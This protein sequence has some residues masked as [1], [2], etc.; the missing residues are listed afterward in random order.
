MPVRVS[1]AG[2][3]ARAAQYGFLAAQG[4]EPAPRARAASTQSFHSQSNFHPP[5]VQVSSDPD[6]SSGDIFLNPNNAPQVGSMIINAKGQL[7]WFRRVTN[8]A[9][10][11]LEVQHYNGQ[12]V[13]TWWHGNVFEGHGINGQDVIMNRSYQIVKILHGGN[14]YST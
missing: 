1:A 5:A 2:S 11:N 7:V 10:F 4:A 3:T 8:S 14:G 12:P 6:T 13:L 9:T